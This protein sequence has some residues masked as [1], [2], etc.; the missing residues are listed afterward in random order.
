VNRRLLDIPLGFALKAL[1]GKGERPPARRAR[2]GSRKRARPA[3]P[4]LPAPTPADEGRG[5]IAYL[6]LAALALGALMLV[7]F[8]AWFTRTIGVI[9]LFVFVIA[10]VFA[11]A[12]PA[13]LE[14]EGQP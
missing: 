9:S 11:I 13:L 12:T 14:E 7:V 4:P 3:P 8:D 6:A 1:L 10:G 5:A 2:G